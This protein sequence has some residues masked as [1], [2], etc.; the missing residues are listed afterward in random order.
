MSK[1]SNRISFFF[2]LFF[3]SQIE[4][5]LARIQN[6]VRSLWTGLRRRI[7]DNGSKIYLICDILQ[8]G[9]VS[10]CFVRDK[11]KKWAGK[12]FNVMAAGQ[13]KNLVEGNK[14]MI[15]AA[16][17]C[18]FCRA[19][20]KTLDMFGTKYQSLD[21]DKMGRKGNMLMNV[22]SAVQG[23]TRSIFQLSRR[24]RKSL[25]FNLAHRDENANFCHL[26]SCFET[27]PRII[28]FNLKHRDEIEI[29]FF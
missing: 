28:S 25:V 7:L 27:R 13:F 21:L 11:S 24:E 5:E 16:S 6:S 8:F 15:F 18:R 9:N 26:I 2:L 22:V 20:K 14:V 17:F 29:Y 3:F 10:S 23:S 4:R 1:V 19:A 12:K